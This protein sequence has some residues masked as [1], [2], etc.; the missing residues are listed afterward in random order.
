MEIVT[1]RLL[2]QGTSLGTNSKGCTATMADFF[3]L[4]VEAVFFGEEVEDLKVERRIPEG[5]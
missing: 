1:V 5:G 2:V 3:L 4:Y